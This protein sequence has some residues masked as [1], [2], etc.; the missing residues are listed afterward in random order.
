MRNILIQLV[1]AIF[2]LVALPAQSE[3]TLSGDKIKTLISGKTLYVTVIRNGRTWKMYH[4][5]DGTSVNSQGAE[6]KWYISDNGEHCNDLVKKA[7]FKCAKVI[8]MGDGTYERV[9]SD[10]NIPLVK[11]TKIVDGKDF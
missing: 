10:G 8:D 7:R 1:A 2:L 4:A 6:G 5:A 3:E 11:W 9:S